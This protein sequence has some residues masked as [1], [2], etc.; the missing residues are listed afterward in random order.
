VPK[1]IRKHSAAVKPRPNVDLRT[2]KLSRPLSQHER[3][4]RARQ[5]RRLQ[6]KQACK[7][8]GKPSR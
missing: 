5:L 8:S 2:S 6:A 3:T 4:L 1:L 7:G